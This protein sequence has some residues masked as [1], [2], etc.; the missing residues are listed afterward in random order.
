MGVV[1]W[2]LTCIR[3]VGQTLVW[4]WKWTRNQQQVYVCW[5][6]WGVKIWMRQWLGQTQSHLHQL[7][8][9]SNK[10]IQS[11]KYYRLYK[12]TSVYSIRANSQTRVWFIENVRLYS[13]PL[14]KQNCQK[15][16]D[17]YPLP[18]LCHSVTLWSTQCQQKV[19]VASLVISSQ[20]DVEQAAYALRDAV[21]YEECWKYGTLK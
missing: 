2:I 8:Y 1:S 16:Q 5:F 17:A 6:P 13:S 10:H 15:K 14:S 19:L 12:T 18:L 20:E 9:C 21:W 4:I 7:N 11:V 3:F